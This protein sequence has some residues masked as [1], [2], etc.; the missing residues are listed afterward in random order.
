MAFITGLF[1]S[2]KS[3]VCPIQQPR[4]R[5]EVFKE[6]FLK[7]RDSTLSFEECVKTCVESVLDPA[8]CD[9]S[10]AS[11]QVIDSHIQHF[12]E[13]LHAIAYIVVSE[14]F[15]LEASFKRELGRAVRE[16]WAQGMAESFY[17]ITW[18]TEEKEK[19]VAAQKW[20]H[21]YFEGLDYLN[22][23]DSELGTTMSREFVS[24]HLEITLI[25]LDAYS[26]Q[27]IQ[28]RIQTRVRQF[29]KDP[30]AFERRGIGVE[31]V[32]ENGHTRFLLDKETE[33]FVNDFASGVTMCW[34]EIEEKNKLLRMCIWHGFTI[35]LL[36]ESILDPKREGTFKTFNS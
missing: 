29:E 31:V 18:I 17:P 10:D 13:A 28:N 8:D 33:Q 23:W 16:K 7:L 9:L 32:V 24:K 34:P 11:R 22:R 4:T 25:A 1:N 27:M 5:K 6:S 2:V 19:G 15:E 35:K 30:A 12:C 14:P 3:H 36:G 20:T 26:R 21:S